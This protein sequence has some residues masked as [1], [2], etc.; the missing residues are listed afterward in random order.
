MRL[1]IH[2]EEASSLFR[3][4]GKNENA[5]TYA[6]GYSFCHNPDFLIRF[7][8]GVGVFEKVKGKRYV[9]D[10]CNGSV[11]LQHFNSDKS[12][13]KDILIEV[14]EYRI[15]IEAKTDNSY[16][17]NRQI[18]KYVDQEL[19]RDWQS[20]SKRFVLILTRR[21]VNQVAYTRIAEKLTT[22]NIELVFATWANVF[23]I[24][25]PLIFSEPTDIAGFVLRE[26]AKFIQK[27][28]EVKIIEKEVLYRKVLKD[29]YNQICN[30]EGKGFYFDGAVKREDFIYP[31]CQ[32]FLACNG[33]ARSSQKKGEYLRRIEDY[34]KLTLDE[35]SN[36]TDEEMRAAFQ[37]H[38][39]FFPQ[40][41]INTKLYHVFSLGK[42]IPVHPDKVEFK[43]PD[44]GYAELE[45]LLTS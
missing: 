13:I 14:G 8:K 28:Y 31:A 6:L 40:D 23:Q 24:I 37:C 42:K 19:N 18:L 30:R 5:L 38:L 17:T 27:D 39:S 9:K 25:R 41:E 3:L 43:G 44:L 21:Q 7:L 4:I 35:I 15:V 10:V 2:R 33:R 1:Q 22:N 32:F 20:Y 26:L 11:A 12:G 34:Q 45:D 29:Y 36:S 16:P